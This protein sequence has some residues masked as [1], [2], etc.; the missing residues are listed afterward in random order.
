[1]LSFNLSLDNF[2]ADTPSFIFAYKTNFLVLT[3]SKDN[4]LG[5][6]VMKH[7]LARPIKS[8]KSGTE[9]MKSSS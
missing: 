2:L 8:M 5:V 4:P 6:K 9:G 7:M 3:Q 1:M